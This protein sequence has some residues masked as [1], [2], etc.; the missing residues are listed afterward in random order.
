[1]SRFARVK[2]RTDNLFYG[3]YVVTAAAGLQA[4]QAMLLMQGYGAYVA[5]FSEE[6]GWSKASLSG[7]AALQRV[8]SGLLGPPQGWMI[9]R[10]GARRVMYTGNLILG[11]GFMLFSQINSLTTFYLCFLMMAV[12]ASLSGFMSVMTT[13]VQWFERRRASA[14]A[15]TQIGMSVGGMLVPVLAWSL[16]TFGWRE[17]AFASGVITIVLGIPL[18]ALMKE[19]PEKYGMLPDGRAPGDIADPTAA[20]AGAGATG[21]AHVVPSTQVEFTPRQALRTRAFWFIGFGHALAVLVVS[22]MMVHLVAHLKEGLGYSI[23]GAAII[24]S[25]MTAVTLVGQ[26]IGGYLGDRYE[27]RLISAFCMFGHAAGLF[28]LAWGTSLLWVG[29][30]TVA[31][32]LAWGMRG[33]LMQAMRADYFG[34]RSFGVIMGFSSMV[35][36]IGN[37]SGPLVAGITAD[38]T[39]SYKTG[40]TIMAILAGLGSIFFF[41]ATKP[42]P[43]APDPLTASDIGAPLA[44]S[45]G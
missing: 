36:M 26:L 40:F 32:G 24:V 5:V 6:F 1:M 33:P 42:N 39:G 17:T 45:G 37:V 11:V 4:L 21:G 20:A 31:H 10:F 27:K 16:V 7:A 41:F 12:G 18:I 29:F 9:T 28:A 43:P 19:E 44:A 3:W 34:R 2:S 30:F 35:V 38:A 15:Y 14:M 25:V 22:S 8:E 23:T 13:I